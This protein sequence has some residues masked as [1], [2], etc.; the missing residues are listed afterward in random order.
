MQSQGDRIPKID[1]SEK[2]K[3]VWAEC[4]KHLKANHEKWACKEY[5]EN[6]KELEDLN[7]FSENK[8]PQLADLSDFLHE[9]TGITLRPNEGFLSARD[10][11]NSLAFRVFS[12]TQQLRHHGNPFYTPEPDLVHE[13]FGHVILLSDRKFADFTQMIGMASIGISDEE[14]DKLSALYSFTV[15]FGLLREDGEI[16]GQGAG[17]MSSF[18]EMEWACSDEPSEECRFSGGLPDMMRPQYKELDCFKAANS[19]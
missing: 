13:F 15:E 2:E 12:S 18:G 10:F 5:L 6:K 1:Q 3:W 11:L 16:K 14:I 7:L 17:V 8:P 9:K 19:S 4:Y